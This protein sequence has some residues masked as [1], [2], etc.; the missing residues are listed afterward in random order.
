[1]RVPIAVASHP[2][3]PLLAY[4][5]VGAACCE[6][7]LYDAVKGRSTNL[8]DGL[9]RPGAH[10]V[11][12]HDLRWS[13]DGS[14]L[15]YCTGSAY[16]SLSRNG[17]EATLLID[18]RLLGTMLTLSPDQRQ[19]SF[20]REVEVW[21]QPLA[22]VAPRRLAGRYAAGQMWPSWSPDGSRIA[23][24]SPTRLGL[25]LTVAPVDG[26]PAVQIV[27]ERDVW[28]YTTATWSPDSR[29]LAISRLHGSLEEKELLVA[30]ARTG[31][32]RCLWA[33]ASRPWVSHGTDASFGP[34]W[35]PEG[36]ALAFIS[37]REGHKHAYVAPS[38]GE[39]LRRLTAGFDDVASVGWAPDGQHLVIV[40]GGGHRQHRVPSIV[41]IADGSVRP[42]VAEAGTCS[43][44]EIDRTRV[45]VQA[46]SS[47]GTLFAFP[48][49]GA[50]EPF[51]LRLAN[52]G[53]AP[54]KTIRS[55]IGE[56]L[57]ADQ[58]AHM[59]P[60]EFTS[61]DGTRIPA[62]LI[63]DP[64]LD[65]CRRH[66]ALIWAYG[67]HGQHAV[68]GWYQGR[69]AALFNHLAMRG[70]V[71]LIVDSRGSEG[72]GAGHARALSLDAG[73]RQ[74]GDAADGAG[75]LAQLGLVDP[76]RI[77]LFG[78]SYG[79]FLAL[80]TMV[81]NPGVFAA[82]ILFAGLYDWDRDYPNS[83]DYV[84]HRFGDRDASPSLY[85]ERNP[86]NQLDRLTAE[87]L[88]VHGT[89]DTNVSIRSS[90]R[91]VS[92]LI[93]MGRSFDYMAYPGERH[94]WVRWQTERDFFGRV[95][96]FLKRT[97]RPAPGEAP[98]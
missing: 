19:V 32:T 29:H 92:A 72:Y 64:A 15:I 2:S 74:A 10:V 38:E 47:D 18:G 87:L 75:Y 58:I 86:L 14:R 36:D 20:V 45:Q 89:A 9:P 90:E 71:I 21:I 1:M 81:D 50:D 13:A 5:L 52:L 61:R 6:I 16:W 98:R 11:E 94:E 8:A 7:R 48:F 49:S 51:G 56:D 40:S 97:L 63:T 62:L 68:V 28:A 44:I 26:G 22:Q 85:Q 83:G 60:V 30:D 55:A 73:G 12:D 35:S 3:E 66:P 54:T 34:A 96:A 77:A 67:S 65:R 95:E 79:A 24:P 82:G 76:G 59:E 84:R 57:E 70:H 17:G 43:S 88:I 31:E 91:L 78:H 23:F 37:N 4:Q 53:G 41:S 42:I 80:R 69:R 39:G 33:D 25:K 27:P 93:D 46:W